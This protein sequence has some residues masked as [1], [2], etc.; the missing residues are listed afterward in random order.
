MGDWEAVFV[1]TCVAFLL[2]LLGYLTGNITTEGDY[3]DE[4]VQAG[5][6]EYVIEGTEAVFQWV[7]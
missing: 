3:R 2:F 6:A 4:A 7:E 5:C 1:I